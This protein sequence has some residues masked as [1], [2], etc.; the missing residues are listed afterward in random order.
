MEADSLNYS[1]LG[2]DAAPGTE[3]FD[4]F[5]KEVVARDDDEGGAEVHRHPAHPRARAR[6]SSD[7]IQALSKRLDGATLGDPAVDGVRMGPLAEPRPGGRGAARASTRSRASRELVYG[8]LDDFEV[9]GADAAKGAFFPALLLYCDRSVR[10]GA[11]RTTSR[12]SAR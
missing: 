10:R 4:L 11:S 5:I 7:V 12:R 6:W 8:D 2:P 9:V 3:E 1:M